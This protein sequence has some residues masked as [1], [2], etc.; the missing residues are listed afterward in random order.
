MPATI[1]ANAV[2]NLE[3]TATLLG[4]NPRTVRDAAVAGDI[5]ARKW[6][7]RWWFSGQALLLWF[8]SVPPKT[9]AKSKRRK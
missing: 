5:P 9:R 1:D 3:E 7:K 6:S 2:Y 8:A 4:L